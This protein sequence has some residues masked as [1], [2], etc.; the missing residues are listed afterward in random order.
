MNNNVSRLRLLYFF[1]FNKKIIRN[2]EFGAGFVFNFGLR[3]CFH[4]YRS[5]N[6]LDIYLTE[7]RK[8]DQLVPVVI[9]VSGGVNMISPQVSFG[10]LGAWVIGYKLW[11]ALLARGLQSLG[12]VCICPDYR[13]F[14]QVHDIF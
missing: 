1:C 5:R 12:Y 6:C 11:S 13:N 14:P 10:I 9:L 4:R 8:V 3:L 2:L 7:Q